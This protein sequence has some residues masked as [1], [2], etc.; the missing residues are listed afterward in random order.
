MGE[1]QYKA[2]LASI[3]IQG[4]IHKNATLAKFDITAVDI[5]AVD[6]TPPHPRIGRACI[7]HAIAY[8]AKRP[9]L[10]LSTWPKQLL[11]YLPLAFELPG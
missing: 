7:C 6:I 4:S 9:N 5:V 10:K 2:T 1:L 8:I 11:G 3:D